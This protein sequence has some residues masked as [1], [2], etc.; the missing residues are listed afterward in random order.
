M[1][2]RKLPVAW[3]TMSAV[4]PSIRSSRVQGVPSGL[5]LYP[6]ISPVL[7]ATSSVTA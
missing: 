1:H 7:P 5:P 3:M 2:F 6:T 4:S